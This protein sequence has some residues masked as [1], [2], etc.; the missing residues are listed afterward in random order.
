MNWFLIEREGV[1]VKVILGS[2]LT[3]ARVPELRDMLCA[4]EEDGVQ[5]L[6]LDCAQTSDL[7]TSLLSLLLAARNSFREPPKTL[8][9]VGVQ[10]SLFSVLETLRLHQHLNA[11][12]E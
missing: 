12:M 5:E 11:R 8:R 1:K 4:I 7:D 2:E 10:P 6:V 9:L 3:A